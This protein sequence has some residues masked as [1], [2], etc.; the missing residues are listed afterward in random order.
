M[1]LG[2]LSST[3]AKSLQ[4]KEAGRSGEL[5]SEWR[6]ARRPRKLVV[7]K[8]LTFRSGTISFRFSHRSYQNADALFLL[9]STVP[10]NKL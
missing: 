3:T 7:N 5:M 9:N 8:F 6:G 1:P 4:M 10:V 2:K